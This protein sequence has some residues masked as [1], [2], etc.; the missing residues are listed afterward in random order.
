MLYAFVMEVKV[1]IYIDVVLRCVNC[2][3][4]VIDFNEIKIAY[5]I[6]E[7]SY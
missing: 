7:G 3:L 6:V 1:G 5:V 4:F 2:F